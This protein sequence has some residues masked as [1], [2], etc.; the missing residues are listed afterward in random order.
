MVTDYMI[1]KA[2]DKIKETTG[3]VKFDDTKILN[4]TDDKLPDYI[5]LRNVVIFITCVIKWC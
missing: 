3:I 2:W 5:T 1:D 4:D